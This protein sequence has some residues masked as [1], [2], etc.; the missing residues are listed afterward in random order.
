MTQPNQKNLPN[1]QRL[2]DFQFTIGTIKGFFY[3]LYFLGALAKRGASN[4]LILPEG[5]EE[6]EQQGKTSAFSA[7]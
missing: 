4:S 2:W 5:G 1:Y 7:M 3:I 6:E